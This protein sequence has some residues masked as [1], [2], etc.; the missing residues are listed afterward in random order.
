MKKIV[1]LGAIAALAGGMI[2][3]DEPAIDIKV[4]T[5]P[6]GATSYTASR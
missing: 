6:S 3:A 1:A 4:A 2:F 5:S